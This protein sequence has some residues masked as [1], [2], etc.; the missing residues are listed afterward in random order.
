MSSL[1]PTL[2]LYQRL[3]HP[4]SANFTLNEEKFIQ[5]QM[6]S[7][8]AA[9]QASQQHLS[10][11][12]QAEVDVAWNDAQVTVDNYNNTFQRD[13]PLG[14]SNPLLPELVMLT[15]E[16]IFSNPVSLEDHVVVIA[17]CMLFVTTISLHIVFHPDR[18][19]SSSLRVLD[20]IR[21]VMT[22]VGPPSH[23]V[24][25]FSQLEPLSDT[26]PRSQRLSL[27]RAI[28][29]R[30]IE[31]WKRLMGTSLLGVFFIENTTLRAFYVRACRVDD[32]HTRIL[33]LQCEEDNGEDMLL[34]YELE[35]L[36]D[37]LIKPGFRWFT[38]EHG[39]CMTAAPPYLLDIIV[40]V[41][42]TPF[43]VQA[44]VNGSLRR[45]E[46]VCSA[47]MTT[48]A[49]FENAPLPIILIILKHSF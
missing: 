40:N 14:I 23:V 29:E 17:F 37:D 6:Q 2:E 12:P 8:V 42:D 9:C 34:D 48:D 45:L 33:T 38:A 24:Q 25:S 47:S 5:D 7:V 1:Q 19:Q 26:F 3:N 44:A 21:A 31:E 39:L 28:E 20:Q 41:P 35:E 27:S 4:G 32:T 46:G 22:S 30:Q 15:H 10:Q 11:F 18:D 13:F 16:K 49:Y 36:F 43:I